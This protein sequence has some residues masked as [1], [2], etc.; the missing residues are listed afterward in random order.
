[1]D[2]PTNLVKEF[3]CLF[4]SFIASN[5][6]KCVNEST[7][8]DAFKKSEIRPLFKKGGRTEKSNYRPISVLSNVSKIYERCL[9]DQIYSYF[10]KIF[11]R[12]Q[13]GFRKG[14]STQHILLTM[15]EKMKISPDNK[16]FCPATLTD[17][18]KAFDFIPY[19]LLIAK[20]NAYGFD[21]E[22]LKLIHSYLYYG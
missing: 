18:S 16:K 20:L 15:I 17:L 3:G 1:M 9:Y 8:V 21:Q 4:S 19:G 6:N 2:I 7:Y 5:V 22:A 13:C 14:I 12:Y 11:S 10:D